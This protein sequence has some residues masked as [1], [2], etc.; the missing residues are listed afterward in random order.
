M[1]WPRF[2]SSAMAM[3][4]MMLV[5]SRANTSATLMAARSFLQLV[6]FN[7]YDDL[8]SHIE[9]LLFCKKCFADP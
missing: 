6:I 4:G 2:V 3:P 9:T 5:L 1:S 8:S 7:I